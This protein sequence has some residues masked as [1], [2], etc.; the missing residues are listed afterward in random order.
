MSK[1]INFNKGFVY[2]AYCDFCDSDAFKL[3]LRAD[4]DEKLTFDFE[5]KKCH[6]DCDINPEDLNING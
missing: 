4:S 5:C 2:Y 1:I 3:R 6:R